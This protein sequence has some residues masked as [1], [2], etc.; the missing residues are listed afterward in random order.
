MPAVWFIISLLSTL[1]FTGITL[2]L[3]TTPGV[4]AVASAITAALAVGSLWLLVE[5]LR[6]ASRSPTP[7]PAGDE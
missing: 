1:F 6:F 7:S 4:S 3:S 5:T 2:G